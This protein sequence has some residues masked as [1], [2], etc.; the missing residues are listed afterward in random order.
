M[1]T[2]ILRRR[3]LCA[4]GIQSEKVLT[5]LS[6]V[7]GNPLCEVVWRPEN[8]HGELTGLLE[9]PAGVSLR[10]RD[11][12]IYSLAWA[13][14]RTL[15]SVQNYRPYIVFQVPRTFCLWL[16]IGTYILPVF[17][18]V[19]CWSY[20]LSSSSSDKLIYYTTSY[21]SRKTN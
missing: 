15:P 6:F 7:A 11:Q 13:A 21:K 9:W 4:V 14:N 10:L 19:I 17:F 1:Y 16:V 18:L 12:Q 3:R 20:L 8:T 2:F 5:Y